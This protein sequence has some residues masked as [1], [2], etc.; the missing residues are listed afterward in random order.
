M[1]KTLRFL[2]MLI[3]LCGSLLLV[4]NGHSK[5]PHLSDE[6]CDGCHLSRGE[7]KKKEAYKLVA[8]QEQLCGGCHS[9]ASVASHPS[10]IRPSKRPPKE[11]PLDWKGELTCST[12]HE[13][14]GKR[15]GLLRTKNRGRD[16]CLGCH[17]KKFFKNMSDM[18]ASGHL[19]AR[20][21]DPGFLGLVDT[22]SLQCLGCHAEEDGIMNVSLGSGGIVSHASRK[23]NHPIG[24]VYDKAYRYGGYR[25]AAT[26]PKFISL[27]DGMVSCISCHSGY[28]RD[29]GKLVMPNENSSL[30]FTCHDI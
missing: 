13:V 6:S 24:R 11:H 23:G 22:F 25:A 15:Q 12:C 2:S 14:H 27:P 20:H 16:Y 21:S 28:S 4:F 18:M 30:C 5:K 8:S 3:V 10:G 1:S 7:V 19:D 9:K 26:L 17:D 29:H